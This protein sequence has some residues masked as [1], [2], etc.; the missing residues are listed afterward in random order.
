[1]AKVSIIIT[2]FNVEDYIISAI[3]SVVSQTIKDIEIIVVDDCSTDK[4]G[5]LIGSLAALD[6]RIRLIRHAENKSVMIARK[7]GVD[8][9]TGEYILFL[10]GDD[11]LMPDACEKAY[12]IAQDEQV[13]VLQFETKLFSDKPEG[14]DAT[15][16][17][18][19]R[20][21]LQS[22]EHKKISVS[23]CGLLDSEAIGGTINFTLWNKLYKSDVLKVANAHVPDEYMNIAEDVL[24]SYLIQYFAHSFA[25]T[26]EKLHRYRLGSGI[27]TTAHLSDKKLAAMAKCIY[28]YTYLK[29][30]TERQETQEL[31]HDTLLRIRRQMFCNVQGVFFHQLDDGQKE[32]FVSLLQS[33]CSADDLVLLFYSALSLGEGVSMVELARECSHLSL[34]SSEKTEAK[35]IGVYYFRVR[36]GGIENV[37][38]MLTAVWVKSGYRVVLF[39]DEKP[40]RS[41][42]E[43]DPN[44]HRV[45]LPEVDESFP[46]TVEARIRV[47]RAAILENGID[48]MVYNAWVNPYLL[49]DEMIV[50]SCGVKLTVHTHGLFCFDVAS[51]NGMWAYHN[52]A[53]GRLYRLADSV[54]SLTDV[55]AAWWRSQ[56][57]RSFKTINPIKLPLD[58]EPSKLSGN[59]V[60]VVGR[61]SPE[62]RVIDAIKIVERVKER[63]PDVSL[64][65]VGKADLRE[66][67]EEVENYIR[68]KKLKSYVTL[69]GFDTNVLPFYQESD[70]LLSTSASEGFGLVLIEG[71]LCGLPL[72]SYMLPN[73]DITR[74]NRGMVTVPQSDIEAAADAIVEILQNDA[75]KKELGKEARESVQAMYGV[76][77]AEIWRNII[78]ETMRP[79]AKPQ[80]ISEMDPSEIAIRIAVDA[81]TKGIWERSQGYAGADVTAMGCGDWR[82]Y[83]EQCKVLSKAL[84]ELANSESYRF[85]LFITAIPRKIKNWFQRRKKKK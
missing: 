58:V 84:K 67:A 83:E 16:E 69:A 13:D 74:E 36:N 5:E 30:W 17:E 9:A 52:S 24:L 68:E 81:Y 8:A 7:T 64:T 31:C 66:Y 72:V 57:V 51:R 22:V 50:K 56:G 63:V 6:S 3:N 48:L 4:T 62:K 65:I 61:I 27:T 25:Y 20:A 40:H 49:L 47:F 42:Y 15:I 71:K 10:D 80:P 38:S 55:D 44:V 37:I 33:Y 32:R 70:L 78:G 29:E 1:M 85:G 21:Y 73:L 75:R 53:L 54:V 60:L 43:I 82:Y 46:E 45:V 59:R 2:A 19:V 14:V 79:K 18:N 28:S 34:F 35:T 76:D 39:T 26:K 12:R 23:P 77:F 41:D 11:M